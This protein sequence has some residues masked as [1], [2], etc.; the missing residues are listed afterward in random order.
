[1]PVRLPP[2]AGHVP[3]ADL[4]ARFARDRDEAAFE[5]LVWRYRKLVLGSV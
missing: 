3:D 1:M 4:L 5:L 2:L